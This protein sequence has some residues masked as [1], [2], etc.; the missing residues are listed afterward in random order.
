MPRLLRPRISAAHSRGAAWFHML[1]PS[2][3]LVDAEGCRQV[4]AGFFSPP[5][6]S[7][8]SSVRGLRLDIER[9]NLKVRILSNP[10]RNVHHKRL[11]VL[12]TGA[13]SRHEDVLLRDHLLDV[14]RD[15]VTKTKHAT[16]R[17][18]PDVH[19]L[20]HC[21]CEIHAAG[22]RRRCHHRAM[23]STPVSVDEPLW[24]PLESVCVTVG[25]QT[26][27]GMWQ[28]SAEARVE[29]PRGGCGPGTCTCGDGSAAHEKMWIT[30]GMN[31]RLR[32]SRTRPGL[33]NG[34]KLTD[35]R[36]ATTDKAQ[37]Q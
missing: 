32:E 5:V 9:H 24:R 27:P 25:A 15:A 20:V 33:E 11:E 18:R 31:M 2:T 6:P 1:T 26:L 22:Q 10:E 13:R 4:G 3:A 29:K 14:A 34:F 17:P 28:E 36:C 21:L 16:R 12:V 7:H 30:G 37:G 19:L 35:C 23:Q 8:S